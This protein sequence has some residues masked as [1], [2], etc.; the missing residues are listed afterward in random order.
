MMWLNILISL[1]FYKQNNYID[2]NLYWHDV[3]WYSKVPSSLTS[4]PNL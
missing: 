2:I 3:A 1:I 4:C